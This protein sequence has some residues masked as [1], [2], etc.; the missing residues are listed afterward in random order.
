MTQPASQKQFS[1]SDLIKLRN[2]LIEKLTRAIESEGISNEQR[3]EFIQQQMGSLYEQAHLALP[4][5]IRN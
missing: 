1:A 4:E 2:Y 3:R 5:E